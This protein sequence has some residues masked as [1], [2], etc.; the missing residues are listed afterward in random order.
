[1]LSTRIL[2]G[3]KGSSPFALVP[4]EVVLDGKQGA[5]MLWFEFLGAIIEVK[6]I[7][8]GYFSAPPEPGSAERAGRLLSPPR[9]VLPAAALQSV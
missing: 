1:M 5:E 8:L 3:L 6:L 2:K 4:H 9:M 7:K